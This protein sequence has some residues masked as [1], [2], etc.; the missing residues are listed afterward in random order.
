MYQ[1]PFK[2]IVFIATLGS[3]MDSQLSWESGKF[4]LA[5]WRHKVGLFPERKP[6]IHP[7]I[8]IILLKKTLIWVR[9]VLVGVWGLSY[10]LNLKFQVWHFQP[11]LLLYL[12]WNPKFF[13]PKTFVSEKFLRPKT[14]LVRKIFSQKIFESKNIESTKIFGQKLFW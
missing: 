3:I 1:N 8:W 2:G 9:V 11:S 4:Q 12:V 13:N 6:P 5:R 14:L 10:I 7:T